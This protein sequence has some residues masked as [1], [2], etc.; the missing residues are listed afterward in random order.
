M[1]APSEYV[2]PSYRPLPERRFQHDDN[3]GKKSLN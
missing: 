3:P 1:A 2:G